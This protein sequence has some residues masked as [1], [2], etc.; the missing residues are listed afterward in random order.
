VGGGQTGGSPSRQNAHIYLPKEFRSRSSRLRVVVVGTEAVELVQG[1]TRRPFDPSTIVR[2]STLTCGGGVRLATL[3]SGSTRSGPRVRPFEC[4]EQARPAYRRVE[5]P[6]DQPYRVTS[7]NEGTLN[8][9]HCQMNDLPQERS[10][11]NGIVA[12]CKFLFQIRGR[13][14][15]FCAEAATRVPWVSYQSTYVN[16]PISDTSVE[17]LILLAPTVIIHARGDRPRRTP[18]HSLLIGTVYQTPVL[19]HNAAHNGPIAKGP[20]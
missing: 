11:R 13:N 17:M 12:S 3:E 18:P 7:M 16:Q 10:I 20:P 15:T 8:I 2:G 4:I 5:G 1:P 6:K 9:A 19:P 14:R